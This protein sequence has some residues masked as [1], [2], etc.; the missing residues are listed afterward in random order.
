L[1]HLPGDEFWQLNAAVGYRS[2]R[3][4]FEVSLGLLN[5]TGQDYFLHPI[6]LYPDLPRQ[7]T[8]AAKVQLNF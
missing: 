7:R 3:R 8:L 5:L 1:S 4:H 2:P 6:N